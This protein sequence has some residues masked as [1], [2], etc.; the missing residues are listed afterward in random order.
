MIMESE[1]YVHIMQIKNIT[2]LYFFFFFFA[3]FKGPTVFMFYI[4]IIMV[5]FCSF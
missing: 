1:K 4:I 2:Q 3:Y 5:L